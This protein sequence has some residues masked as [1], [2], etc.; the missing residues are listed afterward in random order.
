MLG[1]I[2]TRATRR[3]FSEKDLVLIFV[4]DPN[5]TLEGGG[6]VLLSENTM[7]YHHPQCIYGYCMSRAAPFVAKQRGR[8]ARTEQDGRV[9]V[10]GVNQL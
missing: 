2:G 4:F 5:A 3:S 10:S 1:S 8:S 9:I 7:Y 6:G